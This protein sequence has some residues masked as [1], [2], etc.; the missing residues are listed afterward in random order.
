MAVTSAG[1]SGSPV[2]SAARSSAPRRRAARVS[3]CAIR[4]SSTCGSS[5]SAKNFSHGA[6]R[7]AAV[8]PT[9]GIADGV[10]PASDGFHVLSSGSDF[11]TC[12]RIARNA[13]TAALCAEARG[14]TLSSS[15]LEPRGIP[16]CP[17][18]SASGA[19][20][21]RAARAS[22][23]RA[24]ISSA[25][26]DSLLSAPGAGRSGK[27]APWPVRSHVRSAPVTWAARA[28]RSA[29]GARPFS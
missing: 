11:S 5:S 17:A 15:R 19:S 3:V 18:A 28:R 24:M 2:G 7:P 21:G 16:E 4:R 8:R 22:A 26:C 1:R 9:T 25:G 27:G 23:T 29:G 13:V 6:S 20:S 12:A 10:M 14:A